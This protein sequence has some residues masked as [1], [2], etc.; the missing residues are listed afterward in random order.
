MFPPF[1]TT[2]LKILQFVLI[3]LVIIS[4]I[5]VKKHEKEVFSRPRTHP[6][7]FDMCLTLG[8][9][10]VPWV[11]VLWYII[12]PLKANV[13]IY[14]QRIVDVWPIIALCVFWTVILLLATYYDLKLRKKYGGDP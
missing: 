7:S 12:F 11:P 5:Y 13:S 2:I 14:I 1:V 8:V 3:L 6:K 9:I 10:L 4:A